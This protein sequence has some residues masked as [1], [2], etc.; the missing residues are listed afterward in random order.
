M[1][2]ATFAGVNRIVR[3]PQSFV[4]LLLNYLSFYVDPWSSCFAAQLKN[5]Q[6]FETKLKI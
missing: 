1:L 6:G 4:E 2:T 3:A 5:T